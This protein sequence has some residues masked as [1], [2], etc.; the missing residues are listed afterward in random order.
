MHGVTIAMI[1]HYD[2]FI[3]HLKMY[4]SIILENMIWHRPSCHLGLFSIIGCLIVNYVKTLKD[5]R[6]VRNVC[7][8]AC[9]LIF[10]C[11]SSSSS[12]AQEK[13]NQTL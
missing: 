10:L 3:Y 8:T 6:S 4:T 2:I 11:P 9:A 1:L 7:R 5:C 13:F 12:T